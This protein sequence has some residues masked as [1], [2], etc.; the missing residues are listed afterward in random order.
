MNTRAKL[1]AAFAKAEIDLAK[2]RTALAKAGTALARLNLAE[3]KPS[4]KAI[5]AQ[6]GAIDPRNIWESQTSA[7]GDFDLSG[8]SRF[9]KLPE[10]KWTKGIA[11]GIEE[12]DADHQKLIA[13]YNNVIWA[14][15]ARDRKQVASLLEEL[16]NQTEAHFR[17]EENL[18]KNYSYPS[19][20]THQAEH[21]RLLEEL[22]YEIEDWRTDRISS[23]L[24]VWFMYGWLLR[25]IVTEDIPL[26]TALKG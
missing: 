20:A 2:A 7:G 15:K 11:V 5:R 24:L 14:E 22:D 10:I 26:A 25:H 23:S 1:E 21:K 12:I 3:G 6:H 4:A 13:I 17:R 8:R 19:I 18:M 16:G 9:G